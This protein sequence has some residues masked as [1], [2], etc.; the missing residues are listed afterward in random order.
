MQR[1]LILTNLYND[2]NMIYVLT[3]ALICLE[4]WLFRDT[5]VVHI[6]NVVADI[7]LYR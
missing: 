5:F 2:N 6:T 7:I 4:Y 1:D 3:D